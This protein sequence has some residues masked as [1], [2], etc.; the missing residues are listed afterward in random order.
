MANEGIG[1]PERRAIGRLVMSLLLPAKPLVFLGMLALSGARPA[2]AAESAC[3]AVTVQADTGIRARWP[4]LPDRV[5]E[6]FEGR[7]D[8]DPCARVTLSGDTAI[9]VA[10]TLPDGRS[11]ARSVSRPEDV[12]PVVE[13]LLVVPERAEAVAAF[14]PVPDPPQ[15]APARTTLAAPATTSRAP[16]FAPS[17]PVLDRGVPAARRSRPTDSLRVE[18]SVAP[19]ARIGD[20]QRS[21]GVAAFSFLELGGWLAG[22]EGRLDQY[23]RLAGGS[24]SAALELAALGGQRLRFG[25][26]A[27]DFT[28]GPA[29]VLQGTATNVTESSNGEGRITE[30]SSSTV[31]RLLVGTR[32]NFSTDSALRPFAALDGALGPERAPGA[33]LPKDAPRLPLWTVGLALG[34]TVGGAP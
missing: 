26:L 10:V 4:G 1:A 21:V 6:R 31:L 29:L 19:G 25:E 3:A 17:S 5:S 9:S 30:S 8:I 2:L 22:F 32:L 24:E 27:L 34:A 15:P 33:D 12:L 20:G 7:D 28:A 18:L 14:E 16:P 13:A 11:A 23:Q